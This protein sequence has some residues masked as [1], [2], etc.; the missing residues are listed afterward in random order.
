MAWDD[1]LAAMLRAELAAE[2][3]SEK[4]MF[5]GLAFLRHGHMVCGIHRGGAAFRVGKPQETAAC[6]MEGVSPIEM[7][8]R[9]MP[10]MV[11]ADADAMAD[12]GRRSALM[13][14]ALGFVKTLPPKLPASGRRAKAD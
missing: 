1:A 10:G 8:G 12:P 4:K 2:P 9:P 6:A 13:A 14:L 11:A 7:A 5:G 3:V